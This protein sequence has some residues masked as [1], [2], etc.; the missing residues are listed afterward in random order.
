[1]I[2]LKSL[3]VLFLKSRKTAGTSLEIALSRYA[4]SGDI[5]TPV[6]IR[7]EILRTQKGGRPP[8]NWSKDQND[9]KKLIELVSEIEQQKP[10]KEPQLIMKRFADNALF[11]NHDTGKKVRS[12]LG[13]NV[14][15]KA[16]KFTLCRHPYEQ[17]VSTAYYRMRNSNKTFDE[18]VEAVMSNHKPNS[19]IYSLNGTSLVDFFVRY[20][21]LHEDLRV[22]ENRFDIKLTEFMPFAKGDFRTDRRKASEIL[23]TTQKRRCVEANQFDFEYFDYEA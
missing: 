8:Q 13:E 15:N 1:M 9:E 17:L 7:D 14:F 10:K 6:S 12:R 3:D 16:F 19:E 22:I 18:M 5:I 4:Q 2:F 11:K 23:S 20:E 21:K